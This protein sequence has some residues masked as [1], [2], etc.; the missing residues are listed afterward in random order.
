MRTAELADRFLTDLRVTD[1][2]LAVFA[3]LL[4]LAIGLLVGRL[5]KL[6]QS[7]DRLTQIVADQREDMRTSLE[8][9][10]QSAQA[11]A[12][13]AQSLAAQTAN[14]ATSLAMAESAAT[15]ADEAAKAA[16]ESVRAITAQSGQVTSSLTIAEASATAASAAAK[17]A[18]QTAM[19]AEKQL[20]ELT[21]S[22]ARARDTAETARD[23]ANSAK[24]RADTAITADRPHVFASSLRLHGL[25]Q[26][27]GGNGVVPVFLTYEFVNYGRSPALI[28]G[29]SLSVTTSQLPEAPAYGPASTIRQV[30]PVQGTFR[31]PRPIEVF[32]LPPAAVDKLARSEVPIAAFGYVDYGDSQGQDHRTAFMYEFSFRD[33]DESSAFHPTGPESYWQYT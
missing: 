24:Q 2:V 25:K 18:A 11:A 15:A 3:G 20:S 9:A 8:I 27:P 1:V 13:S 29:I 16:A 23:L 10:K 19:A 5:G 32:K 21:A 6:W 14:V 4:L 31:S 26:P 7:A 17:A 30:V 22:I 33:G 12:E 28:K